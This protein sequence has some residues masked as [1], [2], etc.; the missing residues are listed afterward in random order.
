MPSYYYTMQKTVYDW[1]YHSEVSDKSSKSITNGSYW[2]RGKLL[3][4]SSGINAMVYSRG[5]SRDYDQWE[6]LGNPTWGWKNAL[7][8]F[9]KSEDNLVSSIADSYEGKYHGK[10]GL[11][12]INHHRWIEPFTKVIIKAVEEIGYKEIE[13]VHGP[14]YI[15][16]TNL[17]ATASDGERFS[18]AKAFLIP[19]GS[20]ENLHII[21]YSHVTK[22]VFDNEGKVAGVRFILN[23]AKELKALA[24]NEVIL[25]AGAIGTPQ[26][27]M[28]SGIGPEKHLKDLGIKIVTN[29][30]VGENLQDHLI[31]P[32]I[33]KLHKS[34]S[35]PISKEEHLDNLYQYLIYRNGPLSSTGSVSLSGFINTLDK[36][37]KFPDAQFHYFYFKQKDSSILNFL[38]VQGYEE[39]VVKSIMDVNEKQ[40]VLVCWVVLLNPKSI[41]KLELRSSN[42]LDKPK[43]YTNYLNDKEDVDVIVRGIRMHQKLL[44]TKPFIE[45]EV[46]NLKILISGCENQK[47][48]SDNYWEC[49]VRHMSTTIY[50]PVGTA[51]MGPDSDKTSVVNSNLKV[52]G[53]KRVRV[54]DASI[55]PIIV[56]GNTNAPTIMIAEKASDLIKEEFGFKHEEL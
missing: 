40:D 26:I 43:I 50:H 33:V 4:G 5:N 10:R 41:G 42:P 22:L 30:P 49:Y 6:K 28:N 23:E 39:E 15:G 47:Y 51:K 31:V 12:K 2:P 55:M 29:L 11:L 8:Y 32:F 48:D 34:T 16:F 46:E 53:L 37:N 9:K 54:V 38:K 27:L 45:H 52:K 17:Q 25:S 21:K 18:T 44:K 1:A 19:A 3:G 35:K 20:R 24:K 13:D 14:D 36:N 7:K 56:S